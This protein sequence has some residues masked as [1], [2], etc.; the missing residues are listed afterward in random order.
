MIDSPADHPA[1]AAIGVVL[2]LFSLA[3]MVASWRI[4]PRGQR[5]V[6]T[7][8]KGVRTATR[9][10][11]GTDWLH[12]GAAIVFMIVVVG[13]PYLALLYGAL[14]PYV[15]N[16]FSLA[17]LNFDNFRAVLDD[18]AIATA[19]QNTLILAIIGSL[20]TVTWTAA[21]AYLVRRRRGRW[22]RAVETLALLPLA[23]PPLSLGIGIATALLATPG[24]AALYGTVGALFLAQTLRFGAY[25]VQTIA[26]G[27]GQ[28]D[29]DLEAAARASGAG[30][31][32]TAGRVVLPLLARYLAS[33]WVILAAYGLVEVAMSIF[34]YSYSSR[35]VAVLA[36]NEV[37]GGEFG[38][39]CA[40]SFLMA[41]VGL[42]FAIG[43]A[44]V[45]ESVGR[46]KA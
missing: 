46:R 6:S 8:G 13:L 1:A 32:V 19:I 40:L 23:I 12:L 9:R 7:S 41:T 33:A 16:R 15:S 34:L 39:A 20:L 14:S 5:Y 4:A 17:R 18:P 31:F 24:L 27:V 42:V 38:T 22:V 21:V 30:P 26:G 36:F 2:L 28:L 45:L 11:I 3:A 35:T 43:G 29:P 25:G 37:S 10:R 44:R